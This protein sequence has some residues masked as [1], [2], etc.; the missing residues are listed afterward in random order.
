MKLLFISPRWGADVAGGAESA[1]RQLAEGLAQRGHDVEA[2][3]SCS[4]DYRTWASDLPEGT[5]EEKGVLIHRL[6]VVEPR[7]PARFNRWNE[8]LI[9]GSSPVPLEM[10]ERWLLE[11]G[12]VLRG[13]R[14]LIARKADG[15]DLAVAGPY[16]YTSTVQA[17]RYAAASRLPFLLH[18]FAHVEPM[19][20]FPLYDSAL[21]LPTG[22]AFSTPEEQALVAA[23]VPLGHRPHALVGLGIDTMPSGD[24]LRFRREVGLEDRPYL[25]LLGRVD[26]SKGS[27]E[28]LELHRAFRSRHPEC[29]LTLVVMGRPALDLEPEPGVILTGFVP[30]QTRA[31]ALAGALALVQPSYFESFSLVLAEAWVEGRPGLVQAA[32]DVLV[33]Q[34]NRSGGG[35]PFRGYAEY[36]AALELLLADPELASQLGQSGA[37]YVRDNYGWDTVLDGYERLLEQT[38]AAGR[39]TLR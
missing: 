6:P 1:L 29:D 20:S 22:F 25:L 24:P 26:A 32:N 38:C 10:Q 13:L 17:S 9:S 15:T 11:Q 37:R 8:R 2:V 19:L 31:D 7:D 18:P 30:E 34:A 28:A 27:L 21:R 16:L 33:G 23:R 36:E 4:L 14:E 12:P 39:S 35:L 5:T 3:S